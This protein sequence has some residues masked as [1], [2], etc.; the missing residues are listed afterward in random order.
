[1]NFV[2]IVVVIVALGA[3]LLIVLWPLFQDQHAR[4]MF[5]VKGRDRR[6]EREQSRR[7]A[8]EN[9]RDLNI[10]H[11]LGKLSDSE[12]SEMAGG[13]ATQLQSETHG[14]QK[15]AREKKP[16]LS[17]RLGWICPACGNLVRNRD[18]DFCHQCGYQEHKRE[19]VGT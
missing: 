4:P 9:L 11:E 13:L 6:R 3:A 18:L 1:M 12:F 10:E 8:L 19:G 15:G 17:N 2:L 5:F 14:V 7:M 16:T